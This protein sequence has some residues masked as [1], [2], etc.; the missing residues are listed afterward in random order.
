MQNL[1]CLPIHNYDSSE[2]MDDQQYEIDKNDNSVVAKASVKSDV[3]HKRRY[4]REKDCTRIVKS[5]GLCQRHGAKTRKC[6]IPDCDKQAQGNFDGMCKLHFKM[7]KTQLIPKPPTPEDFSPEPVG[8]SVY[9]RI[10]PQSIGWEGDGMEAMPL[11]RHL[12]EGFD[13]LKPRGWHRNEE[14]R[15]RGL[16]PVPNPAVQLEGWERELVWLEICLLSGSPQSSFRHLARSWGRDKGFHMVLAQYICERRG[17]VE[18]KKRVKG[19][20]I[21]RKN[22]RAPIELS[23]SGEDVLLPAS[24]SL[25]MDQ[26]EMEMLGRFDL[27]HNDDVDDPTLNFSHI[28]DFSNWSKRNKRRSPLDFTEQMPITGVHDFPMNS[29]FLP[30]LQQLHDHLQLNALMVH[31]HNQ[32]LAMAPM[33]TAA[34]AK[35]LLPGKMFSR[36]ITGE[37][38]LMS[39]PTNG[40]SPV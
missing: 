19:E 1:L 17:D 9:D 40:F 29:N 14:R 34:A 16:P 11:V 30:N 5:Q 27:H 22:R 39:V 21:T 32:N 4:C 35:Y 2:K 12:K 28:P 31:Q 26:E 36:S 3:K 25:D 10:I 13:Q 7:T 8:E 24:T 38:D 23:P 15:A 20:M 6:K 18:R 37:D 33:T